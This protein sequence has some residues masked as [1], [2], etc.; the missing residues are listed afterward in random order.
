MESL[1]QPAEM[2]PVPPPEQKSGFVDN[3]DQSALKDSIAKKGS[4]S[5]YYAHNYDGQNF[6]D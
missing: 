5:Y 4:N 2:G 3:K 6:N 1:N